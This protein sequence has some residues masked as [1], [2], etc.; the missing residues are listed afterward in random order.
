MNGLALMQ[1]GLKGGRL[2]WKDE[3]RLK[4]RRA[5]RNHWAETE[6]EGEREKDGS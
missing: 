1:R 2:R 4:L 5:D 3:E 6:R